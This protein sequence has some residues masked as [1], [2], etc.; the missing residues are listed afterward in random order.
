L[1]ERFNDETFHRHHRA[2]APTFLDDAE[3]R[4]DQIRQL[5]AFLLS[6]DAS[7]T[8]EDVPG[9]GLRYDLCR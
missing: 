6:I 8:I 2:L 5:V 3:L 1:E 4:Y 7:T 9:D